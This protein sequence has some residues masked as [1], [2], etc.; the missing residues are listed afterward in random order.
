MIAS[1]VDIIAVERVGRAVK[2]SDTFRDHVFT[3]QERAYCDGKAERYAGR[4]AVKEAVSKALGT[5]VGDVAW[6]EIEVVCDDR[7]K[8]ELVLHGAAALLSA[9]KQ[10]HHWSISIAHDNGMAIGFAVAIST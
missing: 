3:S 6:Q 8:P 4:W 1:G 7:G 5:G 2:R 9:E 10:L